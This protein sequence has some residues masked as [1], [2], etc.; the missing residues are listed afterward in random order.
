MDSD[1]NMSRLSKIATFIVFTVMCHIWHNNFA[2]DKTD[3][4][5]LNKTNP[6]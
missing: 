2:C 5:Y 1:F 3:F 6:E 4:Q